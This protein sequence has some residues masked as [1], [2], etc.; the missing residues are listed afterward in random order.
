MEKII[1]EKLFTN[2]DRFMHL[3]LFVEDFGDLRKVYKEAVEKHNQHLLNNNFIDAGFDIFLPK[4]DSEQEKCCGNNIRFL[5][6]VF[7]IDDGLNK[8]NFRIKCCAYIINDIGKRYNTGFYVYPRSSLSKTPLRLANHVGIIDAGY[9]N[10]LIGLF[11]VIY[12]TEEED[13]VE[14]FV[15]PYSR[16]LQICAPGLVPIYVELV[17]TEE[18]LGMKTERGFGGIGST[19]V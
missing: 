2:Y 3:K 15:P 17:E 4:N 12:S 5:G 19:G 8:T 14:Y 1:L 6:R 7:G 10:N 18:E 11:D 13:H 16:L 9:R